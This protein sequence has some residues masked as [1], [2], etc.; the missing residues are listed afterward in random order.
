M[1]C[2]F[3]WPKFVQPIFWSL[4]VMATFIHTIIYYSQADLIHLECQTIV[5]SNSIFSLGNNI[6]FFLFYLSLPGQSHQSFWIPK[7]HLDLG[8]YLFFTFLVF[9]PL[10][11]VSWIMFLLRAI[12]V[13]L[14][15][16]HS[17]SVS[18]HFERK[19]S[20]YVTAC[21]WA[22]SWRPIQIG[23]SRN[24]SEWIFRNPL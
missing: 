23:N 3:W 11:R 10:N 4:C 21:Y 6:I 24:N 7:S 1:L 12:T 18:A 9:V 19:A 15:L 5:S 20:G 2:V 16:K 8:L 14:I 13:D 17:H 22:L